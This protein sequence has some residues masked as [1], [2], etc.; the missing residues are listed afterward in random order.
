MPL[1]DWKVGMLAVYTDTYTNDPKGRVVRTTIIKVGRSY[2]T[3]K[4]GKQFNVTHVPGIEHNPFSS[5]ALLYTP[6][7]YEEF[8][9]QEAVRKEV[10]NQFNDM[11]RCKAD[12]ALTL[13]IGDVLGIEKP[14][15]LQ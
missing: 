4:G 7:Q 9:Y 5:A 14:W 8:V 1:S 6:E 11:G 3:V 10:L 13:R 12:L 15:H 2:V